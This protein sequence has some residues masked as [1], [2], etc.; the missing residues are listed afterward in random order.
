MAATQLQQEN[1]HSCNLLSR[2]CARLEFVGEDD[3][4][5]TPNY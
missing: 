2:Y 5:H 1:P 4:G 3:T